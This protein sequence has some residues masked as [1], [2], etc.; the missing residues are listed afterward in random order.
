MGSTERWLVILAAALAFHVAVAFALDSVDPPR[1]VPRYVTVELEPVVQEVAKP[2][3]PEP[4]PAQE[5]EPDPE[6]EP[7]PPQPTKPPPPQT[8]PR[9]RVAKSL[10]PQP[11]TTTETAA[12]EDVVAV[13]G[14]GDGPVLK[15]EGLAPQGVAVQ[16]GKATR[17]RHGSGGSG[18]GAGGGKGT[19]TGTGDADKAVS[20]ASIKTRAKPKGDYDYFD[21]RKDYP[22]EAKRLGIEGQIK[23]R[24][25][26]SAKGEVTAAKL[27]SKLGHG[28]DE[29]AMKRAKEI[30]FEPARDTD[31]QPVASIVV[32][33][34]TFTLPT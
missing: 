24:L 13:A 17:G 8:Q 22:E 32:W 5:P 25:T 20:V 15:M 7:E 1:Y 3:P 9:Q 30:E 28:L 18:G 10:A 27:L 14:G 4:P 29:L 21:A 31:D 2:K 33:T 26:V 34:F 11:T 23:V 16:P 19:G 12:P 6:P